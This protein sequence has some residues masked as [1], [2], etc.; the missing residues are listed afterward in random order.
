MKAFFSR[1]PPNAQGAI[2]VL[3]SGVTFV[4]M[5]TLV[6]H[7]SGDYPSHVQN[8][9]RQTGSLIVA[10]PFMLRSPGQVLFVPRSTMPALFLRSLLATVGMIL[11]LYTYEAMPMAEANALSFTRPLWVVLLAAIFLR[12]VIG[13]SRIAAVLMGFVGV[14]IIM[15]PWGT[16]VEIGWPHLAAL[17][18]ALC[19]AGTITGVKSLTRNLS[20]SSILVWS[21]I[22]GELLSLPFALADWR[23]PSPG[24]L[25]PLFLIGLLSAANQV[26]FIK[27]MAVG[28]AAVLAPIDYAR[29]VLS[30]IAGLLVFG[31][32]PDAF[33]WVG[34]GVIVVST[35][36]I[37]ILEIR[38]KRARSL[39]IDA[40]QPDA[41]TPLG[42]GAE[43]RPD[44]PR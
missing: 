23:W 44:Q 12:E 41:S 31:E 34:A 20:A 28:E 14:V 35:L 37:T 38:S 9:Y 22:I 6:K 4:T 40:G 33:T 19:L 39:A 30:V 16:G 27:G 5:T 11:L 26:L 1:L 25:I 43:D 2:W 10:I 32:W 36:Y 42:L 15:R 29:L 18:S 7:L 24:D 13:P 3:L 17:I 21:S 8:F